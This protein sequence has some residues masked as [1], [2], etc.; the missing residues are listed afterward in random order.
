MINE[1]GTEKNDN[2]DKKHKKT[3]KFEHQLQSLHYG[4]VDTYCKK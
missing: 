2:K 3:P 4:L 1:R